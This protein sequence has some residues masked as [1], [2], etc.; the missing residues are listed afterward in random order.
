MNLSKNQWRGK[1]LAFNFAKVIEEE[2]KTLQTEYYSNK[3]KG[4]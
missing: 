4:Y 3:D 1:S 2:Q